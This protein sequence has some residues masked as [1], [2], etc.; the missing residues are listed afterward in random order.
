MKLS[1]LLTTSL[2][3]LTAA[4][5]ALGQGLKL[6]PVGER[7]FET[8]RLGSAM[9]G[10]KRGLLEDG[11]V[12]GFAYAKDQDPVTGE[13]AGGL[14]RPL[15]DRLSTLWETSY[16]SS[17]R[18]TNEWSMLGQVGASFGAGWGMQA[19]LR[20]TE[21]GLR[22]M[23]LYS[24]GALKPNTADIGMVTLERYWNSYRGAYT[25]FTG[26]TDSGANASGHRLQFDYFY[27][28]RSSIG[29]AYTLG[30]PADGFNALG[31]TLLD[32]NNVGL[33]GEHWFARSWAVNY[34]ALVEDP[35]NGGGLRPELRVGLR[36]RF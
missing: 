14:Y 16:A 32:T 8:L 18:L 12:N 3:A 22:D 29:L 21:L 20:H 36:L 25:F 2:I 30:L 11:A 1:R 19:G 17:S 34:N 23:P 28:G 6:T 24:T 9:T 26:R 31:N 4:P 7:S 10:W 13:V 33:T 5:I 27:G 35:R 15:S